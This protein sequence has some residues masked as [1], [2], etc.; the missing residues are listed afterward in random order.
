MSELDDRIRA[1]LSAA[2]EAAQRQIH[3]PGAEAV[4]AA[5]QRRSHRTVLAAGTVVALV[6]VGG[7]ATGRWLGSGSPEPVAAP[8]CVPTDATAFLRVDTTDEER[9]QV[10][11]VLAGSSEVT[12]YTFENKDEA[13]ERFRWQ[14]RDAPDLVA[15]TRPENLPE[16]WRF[17]LRCAADFPAVRDRLQTRPM[18]DVICTCEPLTTSRPPTR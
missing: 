10:G 1:A 15:V 2:S 16:S 7:V 8:G 14:F 3:S 13:Y 9:A 4:P 17:R 18:L 6:L 11:D 5:A 12:S